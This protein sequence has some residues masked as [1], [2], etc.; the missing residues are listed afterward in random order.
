MMIFIGF[1]FLLIGLGVFAGGVFSVFKVSRRLDDSAKAEGTVIAF[2]KKAGKRGFI[3]CPQVEFSIP[4]GQSF[5]FE[6]GFG[7][8]FMV[9]S[10]LYGLDG[11]GLCGV[12]SDLV[13]HRSFGRASKVDH[14]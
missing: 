4:N 8:G 11:S 2:G 9:C 14:G 1:L 12:G 3:Y 10:R 6:S 13:R 5:R 7:H